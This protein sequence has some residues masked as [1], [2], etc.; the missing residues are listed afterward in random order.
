M[1]NKKIVLPFFLLFI[2]LLL[3]SFF[4]NFHLSAFN[5]SKVSTTANLSTVS[6]Y[7]TEAKHLKRNP[8]QL[9]KK[10]KG[11]QQNKYKKENTTT[12]LNDFK[13]L[14]SEE[15]EALIDRIKDKSLL[16]KL[17][18]VTLDEEYSSKEEVGAYLLI[19]DNL[20]NNYHS[21]KDRNF[22]SKVLTPKGNVYMIGGDRFMNFEGKLPETKSRKYFEC[23]LYDNEKNRG[24]IRLVYSNDGLIYY[25][26]DHYETFTLLV[27]KSKK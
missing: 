7:T 23:D 8:Y 27:D 13:S 20:P 5:T 22:D 11:K 21:K 3:I 12:N 19:F 25:T 10:A 18:F 6:N 15:Q 2:C 26:D 9:K 24:P 14:S 1:K 4:A 16:A 17:E